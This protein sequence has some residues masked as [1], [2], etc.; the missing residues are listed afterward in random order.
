MNQERRKQ[1][2][3]NILAARIRKV[4]EAER[5]DYDKLQEIRLRTGQPMLKNKGGRIWK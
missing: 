2:I 4:V 5:L 3:L 1:Q